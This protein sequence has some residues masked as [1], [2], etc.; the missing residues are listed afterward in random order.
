MSDDPSF[1]HRAVT[2]S[3]ADTVS[4]Q[5]PRGAAAPLACLLV[6]LFAVSTASFWHMSWSHN[7]DIRLAN[8][9]RDGIGHVWDDLIDASVFQGRPH[10]FK[11]AAYVL[12]HLI[13]AEW[14]SR[15]VMIGLVLLMGVLLAIFMAQVS[16]TVWMGALCFALYSLF[17]QNGFEFS[18]I[19]AFGFPSVS[20]CLFLGAL[21]CFVR[22]LQGKSTKLWIGSSAA[23]FLAASLTYE[24]YALYLPVF[25]GVAALEGRSPRRA[26]AMAGWHAAAVG[27][28]IIVWLWFKFG[29]GGAYNGTQLYLEGG[30]GKIVSLVWSFALWSVPGSVFADAKFQYIAHD[31]L[32]AGGLR[33]AIGGLMVAKLLVGTACLG[34]L[35][36]EGR[37]VSREAAKSGH[38]W[39]RAAVISGL[40]IY[41]FVVPSLLPAL[42]AKYQIQ[43]DGAGYLTSF[44]SLFPFV[45]GLALVFRATCVAR[46]VPLAVGGAVLLVGLMLAGATLTAHT[47]DVVSRAQGGMYRRHQPVNALVQT[48]AFKALPSRAV[49]FAPSLFSTALSLS[50]I[51]TPV[52]S[53]TRDRGLNYWTGYV[54]RVSGTDVYVRKTAAD[55][56]SE[57]TAG[58]YYL[59]LFQENLLDA[60]CFLVFA[61]LLPGP[62]PRATELLVVGAHAGTRLSIPV[63]NSQADVKV[64]ASP[65][66]AVFL[67]SGKATFDLP[68]PRAGK[69][70]RLRI[71]GGAFDLTGIAESQSPPKR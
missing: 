44:Y 62:V 1:R 32:K 68:G 31:L 55:V 4:R 57:P 16:G 66:G 18:P 59:E 67:E 21:L 56:G 7:D 25:A 19:S 51:G 30:V 9:M 41:C 63:V 26:F 22:S 48:E 50:Y 43:Y 6:I 10:V 8:S 14:Y 38:Q 13:D 3:A 28:S 39:R 35:W 69:E 37:R 33:D 45:I 15:A 60:R 58:Q 2:E 40:L 17:L 54:R 12:P 5:R 36:F 47:N 49:I 46:R 11:F 61:E 52:F 20:W 42:T 70:Q 71:E 23:L 29:S 24:L 53:N 34:W 65:G 27:V 64:H